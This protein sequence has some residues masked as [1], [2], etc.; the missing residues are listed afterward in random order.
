MRVERISDFVDGNDRICLPDG[1]KT[2]QSP[3]K[4]ENV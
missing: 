2:M 3:G 1:R 4:F